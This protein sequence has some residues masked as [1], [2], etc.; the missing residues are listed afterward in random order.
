MLLTLQNKILEMIAK[1]QP[2]AEVVDFLC[3]SV[4]D[5]ADDIVCSVLLLDDENRLR[6]LSGPSLP[7]EYAQAIDGIQIGPGV[8]SCGTAAYNGAPVIV[9]DIAT[10]AF[11][12]PYKG[13]VLPL[14]LKACWS[15][16]IIGSGKVLG[17]FGFY[18]R[19]TR[20]PSAVEHN[21][22]AASVHLCAIAIERDQRL[23]ERRKLAETDGLTGLPNRSRFNETITEI[24]RREQ[25]W[26]LVLLDL[27]NLKMVNDTFG[28]AAGDDLI[29][30]AGLRI[31]ER[32]DPGMAFRL[33]GDEFA[34]IVPCLA[35]TDLD[36]LAEDLIAAIK[37]P[38]D[39]SGHLIYPKATLGGARADRE[40]SPDQVRQNADYALYHAKESA[41]GQ[42]VEYVPGLGSAIF[43]RFRAVREVDQALRDDRI[44]AHYQPVIELSTGRIL[45][46]ESLCRMTAPDGRLIEAAQFYEAMK[47][48]HVGIE[49]TNRMLERITRDGGQWAREGLAFSRI[50]FNLTAADF[51]RGRLTERIASACKDNGMA[52]SMIVAE[53]TESVYLTQKDGVVADEIRRL[54][55]LGIKVALDD[56]GTGFA[57]LTH[58]LT[59]PV[60]ILKIDRRFV[61]RLFD[62]GGG[63]V[64][65]QG[66]LDIAEGLGMWVIA[67]G[68][69]E[70]QQ[71]EH[72][73]G[74]DCKGGQGYF[75]SRPLHRDR[76][77]QLLREGGGYH[78]GWKDFVESRFGRRC[79]G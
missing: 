40:L 72:L 63:S 36:R 58:L 31:A 70:E 41:R 66:L 17:T 32:C 4:E 24:A 25:N 26:A 76:A 67:E 48:A 78:P 14:G 11:W 47:D 69:E 23:A 27:D 56:F 33:G 37:S 71:A 51:H 34:I 59:V 62:A 21:L 1:G 15:T 52:P 5:M 22:V 29:R 75:F 54:R 3:R 30:T 18:Y 55:N 35:E 79:Y 9:T 38:A 65:T 20:G 45:G 77:L 10:H 2:L 8:G 53:V 12:V 42:F 64:I 46:F 28:H 19:N 57:S 16:P 50:G 44:D 6:H 7:L 43:E 61:Q 60:D 68:I 74:L 13:L 49:I 39:C 73:L